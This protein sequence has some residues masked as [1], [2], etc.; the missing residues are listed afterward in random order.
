MPNLAKR[1]F[2][3]IAAALFV[4]AIA[5]QWAGH[6]H[7]HQAIS[8]SV[9]RPTNSGELAGWDQARGHQ[10]R[11]AAL[12]GRV[13]LGFALLAIASWLASRSRRE[14]GRP[15]LPVALLVMYVV[16]LLLLG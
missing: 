15:A 6:G 16:S 8:L 2:Y 14:G 10:F 4:A 12:A 5:S 3:P 7:L 11:Q 1:P 9:H 13:G